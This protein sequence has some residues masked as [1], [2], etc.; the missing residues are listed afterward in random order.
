MT[1]HSS[2]F[3]IKISGDVV[4]APES[5]KKMYEGKEY[6]YVFDID[7]DEP[8]MVLKL[9]YNTIDDPWM[10][11][12][13]FIHKHE[14]S[15]QFLDTI[16]NFI[17]QNAKGGEK[18][19]TGG[20]NYCADPLT[21]SGAYVSESSGSA[22]ANGGKATKPFYDLTRRLFASPLRLLHPISN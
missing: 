5:N 11:A 13:R 6:D 3:K 15:Q 21:G 8:K 7:I 10:A 16:A 14:L 17:V 4:G 22:A 9:P 1:F 2:H 18:L 19:G 12:Q 20:G